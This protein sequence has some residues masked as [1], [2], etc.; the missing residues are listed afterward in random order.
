MGAVV[1][2]DGPGPPTVSACGVA[3][4]SALGRNELGALLAAAGLGPPLEHALISLLALTGLRV[5]ETTGADIEH[6]GLD[7]GHRTLTI[8]RKGDK[9]VTIPLVTVA[10]TGPV[11]MP[12][13]S[14]RRTFLRLGPGWHA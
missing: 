6:L 7:R 9:V 12:R 3:A 8:S 13:R 4:A 2:R 1:G 5:S 11:H 10:P 14:V